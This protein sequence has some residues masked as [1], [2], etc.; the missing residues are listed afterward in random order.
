M[1]V[2]PDASG[3]GYEVPDPHLGGQHDLS[4][5][6]P[7]EEHVVAAL[8]DASQ[9]KGPFNPLTR[10]VRVAPEGD[11]HYAVGANP[12]ASANSPYL[13]DTVVEYIKVTYP[14]KI[15][16]I[17]DGAATDPVTITEMR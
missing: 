17:Q 16:L 15:A 1:S 9:Q 7:H 6:T 5:L 11:C 13:P 12:T 3:N 4:A 2:V 8:S 14:E 10:Y